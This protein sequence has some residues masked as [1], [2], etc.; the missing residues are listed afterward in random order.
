MIHIVLFK[1]R[2]IGILYFTKRLSANPCYDTPKERY[3]K[4]KMNGP[5]VHERRKRT[6]EAAHTSC[7]LERVY[8]RATGQCKNL[9]RSHTIMSPKKTYHR[10]YNPAA[11]GSGRGWYAGGYS[12]R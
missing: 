12:L 7:Y 1:D 8:Q 5:T 6:E 3:N 11:H 2:P 4:S 10:I 9:G